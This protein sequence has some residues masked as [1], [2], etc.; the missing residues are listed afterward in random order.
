MIRQFAPL[1]QRQSHRQL[2]PLLLIDNKDQPHFFTTGVR[3]AVKA[4]MVLL[5]THLKAV[6]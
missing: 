2:R 1:P 4:D 3:G 5:T 6:S